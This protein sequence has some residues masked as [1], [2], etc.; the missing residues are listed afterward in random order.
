MRIADVPAMSRNKSKDPAFEALRAAGA[1]K[2]P[3]MDQDA[4]TAP[5]EEAV[6]TY[7]ARVRAR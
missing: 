5:A 7:V 3:A 4:E 6:A 1:A 2:R